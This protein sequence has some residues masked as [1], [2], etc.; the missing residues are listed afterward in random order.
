MAKPPKCK[1]CKAPATIKLPITWV[2]S[3]KC[4]LEL[5]EIAKAKKLARDAKKA[6]KVRKE[7][8]DKLKTRKQHEAVAKTAMQLYARLR[9]TL[10]GLGCCSCDKPA[11]HVNV[12]QGSHF[13]P[14]TN[15]ATRF[16]LWNINKSCHQCNLF[17][18]G[19]IAG[20]EPRLVEKIGQSKVDWLKSQNHVVKYSIEYMKRLTAIFNRKARILK[21]RIEKHPP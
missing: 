10:A 9:D 15:S 18:G 3:F 16:N 8:L 2:C 13:R 12:W 19:E 11:N 14:A 7:G 20:Y 17:K 5:V 1:V 4:A 6:R 21:K